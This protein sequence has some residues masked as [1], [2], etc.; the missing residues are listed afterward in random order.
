[1][2]ICIKPFKAS[3]VGEIDLKKG[4]LVEVLSIGDSGYWEGRCVNGLSEG[5]FK[6]ACVEEFMHAEHDLDESI[7]VKRKTLFD[8]IAHYDLSALR[9]VVLQRGKK[10][11]GFVLRGAKSNFDN[12]S[13]LNWE[14]LKPCSD[15][16]SVLKV[17]FSLAIIIFFLWLNFLYFEDIYKKILIKAAYI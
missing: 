6:A 14:N 9:T 16:Q 13:D 11:F 8:L 17:I 7:V 15:L 12:F 1:M 5:W 2:F 10:G 3:Q 4:D